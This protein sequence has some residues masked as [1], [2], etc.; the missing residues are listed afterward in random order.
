MDEDTKTAVVD[1]K[2]FILSNVAL[3]QDVDTAVLSVQQ[4]L[5]QMKN[6]LDVL[7]TAVDGYVKLGD[8]YRQE[9]QAMRYELDKHNAWFKQIQDKLDLKFES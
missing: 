3:K 9:V 1:L 5:K 4:D 8:T 7:T 6:S 2:S